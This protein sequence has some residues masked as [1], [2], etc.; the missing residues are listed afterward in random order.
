MIGDS[1]V[2]E[3]PMVRPIAFAVVSFVLT[4]L[5]LL[6]QFRIAGLL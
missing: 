5:M 1:P 6:G 4:S 2:R 3:V